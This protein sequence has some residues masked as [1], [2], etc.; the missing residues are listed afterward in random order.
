[1]KRIPI[2]HVDAFT[3]RPFGGN[4]AGVVPSAEGLND[5][6]M[7]SIANEMNLS[8]T[9]FVLQS[10][11]ADFR[12]RWFTP[13]REI[14]FCGHATVASLHVLAEENR[15]GM[16]RDGLFSFNIET[17]VGILHVEVEKNGRSIRVVL[18]SP[19][20]DLVR[21]ELNGEKLAEALC[22]KTTDIDDSYPLMRERTLD[23]LYVPLKRLDTLK[24]MNYDYNELEKIGKKHE[25]KGFTILTKETFESDSHVHS[26]FFTP[27]YGLRED[28]TTGSSHGPL[29]A[30][31][32]INGFVKLDEKGEVEIKAEQGDIIGRPGRMI[33]KVTQQKDGMYGAKL[34]STA[35]TML[36]GELILP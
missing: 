16:N 15:F 1:M 8:E 36:E 3:D 13:K 18:Q 35:V 22:I 23:Y 12:I 24:H 29:G 5:V 27:Y 25:I 6:E 17:M 21:E 14:Q 20:I 10:K 9:A 31:L 34:I 28:P 7:Q 2:K 33:V 11:K 32:V 19:P 4:P 26:R 30:Y